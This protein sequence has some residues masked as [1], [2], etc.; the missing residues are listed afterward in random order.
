MVA[1]IAANYEESFCNWRGRKVAW[2]EYGS[3]IPL[4]KALSL[5]V[6]YRP[7]GHQVPPGYALEN[8]TSNG[9]KTQMAR[10]NG[11]IFNAQ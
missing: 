3:L 4:N 1:S 11:M 7:A 9:T 2:L 5:K 8:Y 10:N 6:D